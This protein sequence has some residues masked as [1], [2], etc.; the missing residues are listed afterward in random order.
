VKI[1]TKLLIKHRVGCAAVRAVRDGQWGTPW[2]SCDSDGV[3][4]DA[5]GG[6]C[7]NSHHWL[8]VRC[9]DADCPAKLLI[10][11]SDV[12]NAVLASDGAEFH[13]QTE[14]SKREPATC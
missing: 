5:R 10:H 1:R 7:G 11:D 9:N 3:W 2:S 14:S 8:R 12:M 4:R 13:L 6:H